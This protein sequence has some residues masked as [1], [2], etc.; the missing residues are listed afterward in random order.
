[1]FRRRKV[2]LTELAEVARPE[3]PEVRL[4]E[5]RL[6]EVKL[7]DL[8]LPDLK[9]PEVR[10]PDVRV[11]EVRLRDVQLPEVR[12]RDVQL[13]Q[14]RLPDVQVPELRVPSLELA[15]LR[16]PELELGGRAPF[17][18]RRRSNPVWTGLKFALG[19]GLGLAVGCL[20]AA[21]LAPA[22]GEDIRQM[23]RERVRGRGQLPLPDEAVT[24]S[25]AVTRGTRVSTASN[26]GPVGELRSRVEAAQAAMEQER[27]TRENELWVRFR[28]A[29]QTGRSSEV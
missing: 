6:P 17:V 4:R 15:G 7:P 29:V 20:V 22:A 16:T 11:P 27:R 1:V 9:V 25:G 24:N 12:L 3:L 13:P 26:T 23:L 2:K 28:R 14:V 5:L 18:R 10:L 19:L 8:K 21:L